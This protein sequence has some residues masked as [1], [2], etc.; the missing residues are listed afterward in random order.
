MKWEIGFVRRLLNESDRII[1]DLERRV[2]PK[3]KEKVE[4]E[5]EKKVLKMEIERLVKEVANYGVLPNI[6]V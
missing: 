4:I 2:D 6:V 1:E 3:T 5:K